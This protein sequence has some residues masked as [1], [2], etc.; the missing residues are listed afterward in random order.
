MQPG[1][2][3]CGRRILEANQFSPAN[4]IGDLAAPL[5][6]GPGVGQ[7]HRKVP[8]RTE[9]QAPEAVQAGRT[10][11]DQLTGRNLCEALS[12]SG[13]FALEHGRGNIRPA[14]SQR[15]GF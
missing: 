6:R 3:T 5:S 9:L 2:G 13:T 1:P 7:G 12:K 4:M 15:T 11:C 8:G 14:Q 10:I